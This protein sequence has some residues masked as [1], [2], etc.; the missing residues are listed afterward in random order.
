MSEY[1]DQLFGKF[2]NAVKT[3][4]EELSN[5]LELVVNKAH[6]N[7]D[8]L[9]ANVVWGMNKVIDGYNALRTKYGLDDPEVRKELELD[10]TDTA[11]VEKMK[12]VTK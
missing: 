10:P 1:I 8:I 2:D 6:F 9:E 5:E 4:L 11:P 12:V 7:I 3:G